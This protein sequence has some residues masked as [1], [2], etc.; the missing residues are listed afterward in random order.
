M[1]KL[2]NIVPIKNHSRIFIGLG[3]SPNEIEMDVDLGLICVEESEEHKV[4][5]TFFLNRS[6]NGDAIKFLEDNEYFMKKK[7]T[8]KEVYDVIEVRLDEIPEDIQSMKI[9]I[10]LYKGHERE[11]DLSMGQYTIFLADPD[12]NQKLLEYEL[13]GNFRNKTGIFVAN[14][15]RNNG[16][17][18]FKP[19]G[20]GVDTNDMEEM[21]LMNEYDLRRLVQW[22][23]EMIETLKKKRINWFQKLFM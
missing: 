3:S 18:V 14:I 7:L 13:E 22:Q 16:Y 10:C 2:L 21:F 20:E 17:W 11:Q 23:R 4:H 15:Y 19:I 9:I 5:R 6:F 8:D 12:N 1:C